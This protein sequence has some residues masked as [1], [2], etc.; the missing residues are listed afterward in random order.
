Q[1]SWRG[2]QLPPLHHFRFFIQHTVVADLIPHVQPHCQPLALH[3]PSPPPQIAGLL[4]FRL[5]LTS[6]LIIASLTR[7][8]VGDR[9]SHLIPRYMPPANALYCARSSTTTVSASSRFC[10]RCSTIPSFK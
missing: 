3:L 5:H 1:G 8:T 4:I 2:L 6:A 7:R 9:P 10:G